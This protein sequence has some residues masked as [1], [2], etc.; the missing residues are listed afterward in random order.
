MT[1]RVKTHLPNERPAAHNPG[2]ETAT[3]EFPSGVFL[4]RTD[5][6]SAGLVAP[7]PVPSILWMALDRTQPNNPYAPQGRNV[8]W[9]HIREWQTDA[10]RA[11]ADS[12]QNKWTFSWPISSRG[13]LFLLSTS[14][15]DRSTHARNSPVGDSVAK[16]TYTV[17]MR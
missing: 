5:A 14:A 3:V 11:A 4:Q 10:V 8:T 9:A 1:R 2:K 15:E 17:R 7:T 12:H 13:E 16:A 6:P